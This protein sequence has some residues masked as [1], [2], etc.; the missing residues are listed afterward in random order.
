MSGKK[1]IFAIINI[2]LLVAVAAF[3]IVWINRDDGQP[4]PTEVSF[5]AEPDK[6][7]LEQTDAQTDA[8]IVDRGQGAYIESIGGLENNSDSTWNYYVNGQDTDTTPES[9][10]T[11]GG[12]LI[13]WKYEKSPIN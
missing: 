13:E 7:I 1:K 6:T 10:T 4:A 12:E 2:I 8:K 3:V 11:K 5:T 9:Y